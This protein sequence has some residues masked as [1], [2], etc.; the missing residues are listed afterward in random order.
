MADFARQDRRRLQPFRAILHS[1]ERDSKS[2]GVRSSGVASLD[3][4][5]KSHAP[6]SQESTID[7]EEFLEGEL[8]GQSPTKVRVQN[9]CKTVGG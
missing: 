4:I 3:T 1:E 7:V 2:F 9:N 6:A 8:A 5:H